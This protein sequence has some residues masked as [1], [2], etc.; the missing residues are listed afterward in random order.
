[1]FLFGCH[2]QGAG[3]RM[4][5]ELPPLEHD[6]L[7]SSLQPWVSSLSACL[8]DRDVVPGQHTEDK[9]RL[10]L[11]INESGQVQS[12][13]VKLDDPDVTECITRRASDWVFPRGS[14]T[15]ADVELRLE[16]KS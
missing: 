11:S 10:Q 7:E 5:G 14:S 9:A 6:L 2:A 3:A 1:M 16:S 12:V 4:S 8:V 13:V 15:A